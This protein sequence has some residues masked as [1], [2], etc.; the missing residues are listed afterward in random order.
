MPCRQSHGLCRDFAVR[1]C[2]VYFLWADSCDLLQASLTED[3]IPITCCNRLE[4]QA[5]WPIEL[6]MPLPAQTLSFLMESLRL[7]T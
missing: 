7:L 3:T 4:E 1:N 6:P 2:F 5:E